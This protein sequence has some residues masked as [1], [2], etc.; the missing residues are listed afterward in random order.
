MYFIVNIFLI[1]KFKLMSDINR[2]LLSIILE[3]KLKSETLDI[4]DDPDV[5]AG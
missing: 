4:K 2:D 3:F 5:L 1:N